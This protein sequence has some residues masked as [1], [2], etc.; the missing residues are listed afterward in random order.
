MRLRARILLAALLFT[1]ST[2]LS[3]QVL[4]SKESPEDSLGN[5]NTQTMEKG[6]ESDLPGEISGFLP[7]F[8]WNPSF[9]L[10]D[11]EL[12]PGDTFNVHFWGAKNFST[13]VY[14]SPS[15]ELFL[16]GIGAISVRGL[17]LK[18]LKARIIKDL[19]RRLGNTNVAISLNR[20]REFKIGIRGAV[21]NPG[22]KS[23]NQMMR[24]SDFLVKAG[25]LTANA[26]LLNIQIHNILR[27]TDS[28]IN[29]QKFSLQGDESG[30]PF[31]IDGDS[32]F[33]S[34]K[35]NE[36]VIKG[37]VQIPGRFQFS[38]ESVSLQEIVER[39]LGG[40]SA[41]SRTEGQISIT[42]LT[43]KGPRTH[44]VSQK[45]FF[46]PK[47]SENYFEFKL[48]DGD[49]IYFPAPIVN[50]P[51]QG[52][53]VFVTGNVQVPGPQRFKSGTS[54][55]TYISGAGGVTG[56]ANFDGVVVYKSSGLKV[57]IKENPAIDPGDTIYVPEVTFKFWQDH[58]A[59]LTTFLAVVTTTIAISR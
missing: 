38:G 14:V 56:R 2:S 29:Y 50:N 44:S 22:E 28:H 49:Q 9:P 1:L 43:E 3:A 23:A 48:K 11:Y 31:L 19:R 12:G 5:P 17:K 53:V 15:Y 26:D 24:L 59:I 7:K 20:P 51:S 30:N 54:I 36:A 40:L 58:L 33:V 35:K 37:A 10:E 55:G 34:F 21:G 45:D 13:T 46:D 16:P 25:G 52:D 42:R 8:Q 27:K 39:E 6:A 18:N 57:W 41:N 4:S 32:I 47:N